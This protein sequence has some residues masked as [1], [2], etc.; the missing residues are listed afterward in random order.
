MSDDAIAELEQ[1]LDP[2]LPRNQRAIASCQWTWEN[3]LLMARLNIWGYLAV[4]ILVTSCI[5]LKDLLMAIGIEN[6]WVRVFIGAAAF[7]VSGY[8]FLAFL[9]SGWAKGL[10][11]RRES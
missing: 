2:S 9:R 8:G 10:L 7:M 5:F 3:G 6:L 4:G 1:R 11:R